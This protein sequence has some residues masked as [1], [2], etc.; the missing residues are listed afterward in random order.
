MMPLTNSGCEI[1]LAWDSCRSGVFERTFVVDLV[2]VDVHSPEQLLD[3]R[4]AHLLAHV[5]QDCALSV[6]LRN[7]GIRSVL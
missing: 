4:L 7:A 2:V 3:F 1:R 5:H 6:L